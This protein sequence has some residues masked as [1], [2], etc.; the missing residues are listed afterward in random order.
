MSCVLLSRQTP[1]I[2]DQWTDRHYE[3]R[4]NGETN[5]NMI[6]GQTPRTTDGWA[7]KTI[8]TINVVRTDT[9]SDRFNLERK[10]TTTTNMIDG[11]TPRMTD[12]L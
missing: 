7:Q 10:D 3:Q 9:M 1:Q 5:T 8:Q 2:T 12:E 11:Q 4:M 6:A